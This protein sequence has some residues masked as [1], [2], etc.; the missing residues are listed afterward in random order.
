MEMVSSTEGWSTITGWKRRSSAASFS[1]CWRYSLRV[2]APMQWSSPRASIGFKR[3]PASTAPS[4]APAPTTVWSSSM[5]RMISSCG[6]LHFFEDRLEP[7][8]E[9]AAVL[10]PGQERPHVQ[11]HDALPLQPFRNIPPDDPLGQALHDG[12][13]ADPGFPDEDGVV[14]GPSREHLDDPTDFLIPADHRIQLPLLGQLRLVPPVARE[15]LIRPL[16]R[17]AGHPLMAPNLGH[18]GEQTLPGESGLAQESGRSPTAR[19]VGQ[20]EQ[21]VLDAHVLVLEMLGFRLRGGQ[22]LIQAWRDIHLPRRPPTPAHLRQARQG[23][24][25]S[26]CGSRRGRRRR[27]GRYGATA[28]FSC[29]RSA[30]SRCSLS[31]C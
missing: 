16:G 1:T 9:F 5:N 15:R 17:G 8:L 30:S 24:G 7:L 4:A 2:V 27:P 29:S 25:R 23:L 21:Q 26:A 6:F 3:F 18:G 13:L 22:S 11:G 12:G 20:G 14:L 19:L 10:G 28:P 31:T